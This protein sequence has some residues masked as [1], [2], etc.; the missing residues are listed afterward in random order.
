M[1]INDPTFIDPDLSGSYFWQSTLSDEPDPQD[2]KWKLGV[3]LTPLKDVIDNYNGY[4][5]LRK[6][7]CSADHFTQERLVDIHKTVYD[8]PYDIVPED[9]IEAIFH[10]DSH[11][12]K[13]NRFWCSA[14]VGYIYTK[15]CVLDENTDWS[16]LRPSDFSIESQHLTFNDNCSLDDC[17]LRIH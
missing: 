2:G 17:E 11:P 12:Q 13:T 16:I 3:Q 1:V 7:D 8:K 15:C 4:V 6:V 10:K 9:W 14:L 5:Y